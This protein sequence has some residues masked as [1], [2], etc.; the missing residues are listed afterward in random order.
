[1]NIREYF[2]QNHAQASNQILLN[3]L[4]Y[5]FLF[6]I[7]RAD[8]EKNKVET[9]RILFDELNSRGGGLSAWMNT[10]YIYDTFSI[11]CNSRYNII[12]S[13][14]CITYQLNVFFP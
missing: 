5:Q 8:I 13:Y 3:H 11:V 7:L 2:D 14:G 6:E 9:M 10:N 4:K 12:P 1:M